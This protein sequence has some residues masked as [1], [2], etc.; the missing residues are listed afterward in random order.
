MAPVVLAIATPLQRPSQACADTLPTSNRT[1][2]TALVGLPDAR[3]GRILPHKASRL[4]AT[5]D[6]A[7]TSIVDTSAKR[8]TTIDGETHRLSLHAARGVGSAWELGFT[9][10]LVHHSG[11]FLDSPIESWHDA[12]R[13]PNGNRDR[14]PEDRLRFAYAEDQNS[15]Y[16]LTD[17][18]GGIG[19]LQLHAARRLADGLAL[20][21][22]AKLPTGS[23][24]RLTG[25]GS[26]ALA[27]G[28]HN[29]RQ[30]G[31]A[32]TWHGSVGG[33]VT[34]RGSNDVLGRRARGALAYASTTL[35]WTLAPTLT[36]KAQLDA[37]SAAYENTGAPLDAAS[38]MLS[39]AAAF[40]LSDSW[41]LELGFSEDIRV[42]SAPD[43]VFHAG[44][45]AR[46]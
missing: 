6:V 36:L 20:R 25:N 10:P 3:G 16:S 18:G 35:S 37:H 45:R 9:L 27:I 24:R 43:I 38:L 40:T 7:N 19:D 41:A 22:S 4:E 28:L 44:L 2:F 8:L 30:V 12:F 5:I 14:L 13:L 21:L 17:S 31:D 26:S 42:E 46:F 34:D 11:G 29:S 1:P 23:S 33:L 32:L 15:V 39:F